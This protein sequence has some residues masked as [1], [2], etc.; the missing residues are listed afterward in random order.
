[1]AEFKSFKLKEMQTSQCSLF[2][3]FCQLIIFA[4]HLFLFH[5]PSERKDFIIVKRRGPPFALAVAAYIS[6]GLFNDLVH[7]HLHSPFA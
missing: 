7:D 4:V 6:K 3:K 1:M 2:S 5:A